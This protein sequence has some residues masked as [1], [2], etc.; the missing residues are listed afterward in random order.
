MAFRMMDVGK[1][2]ALGVITLMLV[3][4]MVGAIMFVLPRIFGRSQA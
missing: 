2:S 4:T 3:L 1:A